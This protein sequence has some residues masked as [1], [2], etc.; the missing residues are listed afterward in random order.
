MGCPKGKLQRLQIV[1][2]LVLDTILKKL[3]FTRGLY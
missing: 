3:L 2:D 1:F